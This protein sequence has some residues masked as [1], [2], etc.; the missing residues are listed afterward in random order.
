MPATQLPPRRIAS[1]LAVMAIV[2]AILGVV[3]AGIAIPFAGVVGISARDASDAIDSLP[4]ELDTQALAQRTVILDDQGDTIATLYDQNR[5]EVPLRQVSRIMVKAIV[6][7]EDYR[8][9]EHGA[10]D[11]KGT[12]RAF[13]TNQA[14]DGT[15]QGGSSITQQL[16]K[17]TLINQAKTKA[18]VRAATASTYQ[19]KLRELRYAI[20]LEQKHSKDWILERYLNIAYFGDGAYGIQ[21][22]AKH[23]FNVNAHDLTLQ[24][25]AMLAG[26]VKN[27]TGYDPTNSPDR[28]LERRNVVL[29]RMAQ[30]HVISENKAERI[31]KTA[32]G[33]DVQPSPNGC[34]NSSAPFFCSYVVS[35]L[36]Q[37]PAL[38]RTAR[39]RK[40]LLYSGGLTIQTTLNARDQKASDTAVA[41]HVYPTDRAIGALAMIE[42]G[43]GDVK[44]LAQSR[45][46]GSDAAQGQTFLNFTVPKKYGDASGFQPGSTFKAFVLASAINQG[47]PLTTQI[48]SPDTIT[49]NQGDF[50]VCDGQYYPSTQPY[51]VHNSTGYGTFDLYSGTRES[52]NTFYVQLE[53]RTGLCEPYTL[54]QKMGI[55]QLQDTNQW[56]VPSFTLGVADVSP[57]EMAEAYATFAARGEHCAA[58][59]VTSI[60]DSNGNTLKSYPEQCEQVMPQSTADAVNA[61]LR[62]VQEPG[63]F[64][65]AQ[66]LQLDK[67]SAAKTG[68]TSGNQSVWYV[69]YT[70]ALATASMVAGVKPNGDQETLNYKVIGGSSVASAFGSTLAGPMWGQAMHAIEDTL[71]STDFTV[72]SA[73][74]V[75]GLVTSVPSVAGMSLDQAERTLQAAG[76]T[77][78]L[79]GYRD[80]GYAQG[81]VVYTYPGAGSSVSNSTPITIYQSTGQEPRSPG[82]GRG[83]GNGKGRGNG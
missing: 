40:R 57:L 81:T 69:G 80:S 51:P 5:V 43:T 19:R 14:N 78:S 2:S 29:D 50:K 20:A 45:P 76:F 13:L 24:Q 8:F 70:P 49:V 35:Y 42:P 68:T 82:K 9:Y 12:L 28:A 71:P 62:G 48:N 55:T 22:A 18:E 34:V 23:Y 41:D 15:V 7:I 37:D 6:S 36:M 63:G 72:P 10:L 32:L 61:V 73:T 33:L 60:E 31:K 65:Y 53:E 39:D 27:P 21:A 67:P 74:D 75:A 59:P 1:H 52:V 25:A 58:R 46:M 16:V 4:E 11:L 44:A 56:M 47:I 83:K 3:V 17:Q 30:L 54:A 64:G 77:T 66:G 26:L 79:G 38:G